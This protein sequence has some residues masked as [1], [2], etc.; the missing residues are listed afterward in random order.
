MT[1]KQPEG[2]YACLNIL[3]C[4]NLHLDCWIFPL[5]MLMV[6]LHD[7]VLKMSCMTT[8]YY[9][10]KYFLAANK[11]T[12]QEIYLYTVIRAVNPCKEWDRCLYSH[13]FSLL[14]SPSSS[15]M[16][17]V[18]PI[19]DLHGWEP[20]SLVKGERLMRC[21]LASVHRLFDL[22]GWAQISRTCLTV[23]PAGCSHHITV[24]CDTHT[25][26][27]SGLCVCVCDF[28]PDSCVSVKSRNTSWCFPMAWPSAR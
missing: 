20:S 2:F 5:I 23:G 6:K 21:K 8:E 4:R 27:T 7:L 17:M 14:F 11:N 1:V 25:L 15:D 24:G 10:L 12:I 3:H 13:Y 26:L 18:T 19:N 9:A 16:M 22:F 28:V